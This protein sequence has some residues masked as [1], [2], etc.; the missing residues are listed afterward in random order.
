MT[1]PD[2]G[3]LIGVAL[4]LLAYAL[5]QLGRLKMDAGAALL[6]NF[7]G[8]SLVLVSLLFRF[9]LAAFVVEAAW[10]LLSLFGLVKLLI[11]RK[12]DRSSASQDRP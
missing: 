1:L 5:V 3:G 12:A 9:N 2:F 7:V 6:M 8:A 10:A 11:R 4:V